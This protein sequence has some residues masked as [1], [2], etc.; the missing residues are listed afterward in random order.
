MT[1][2]FRP[3][4]SKLIIVAH[5]PAP[6]PARPA[7]EQRKTKENKG[8][9]TRNLTDAQEL[10]SHA[11]SEASMACV[12]KTIRSPNCTCLGWLVDGTAVM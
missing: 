4:N 11:K 6:T 12:K 2:Q 5:T 1:M 8:N 3:A 9:N 10:A 7:L